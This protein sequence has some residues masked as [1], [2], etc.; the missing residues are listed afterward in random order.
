MRKRDGIPTADLEALV[1]ELK[2]KVPKRKFSLFSC[3]QF[4]R[5]GR[6][7]SCLSLAD[8]NKQNQ[9]GPASSQVKQRDH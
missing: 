9:R 8:F 6:W 7:N 1:H 4:S 5:Q 2:K 3:G